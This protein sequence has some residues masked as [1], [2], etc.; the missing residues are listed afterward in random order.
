MKTYDEIRAQVNE[1]LAE[2][3]E[4]LS[5][6]NKKAMRT[7]GNLELLDIVSSAMATL[8]NAITKA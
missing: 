2:Q 4:L 5:E 3:V 1:K 8:A 6:L 7:D